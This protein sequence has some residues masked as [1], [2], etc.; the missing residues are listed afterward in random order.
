[1]VRKQLEAKQQKER[2]ELAKREALQVQEVKTWEQDKSNLPPIIHFPSKSALNLTPL[3]SP[4]ALSHQRFGP[5]S[6]AP[7]SNSLA[8]QRAKEKIEQLK[9]A[10]LQ[11]MQQFFPKTIAHTAA[12][13][14][15]RVAHTVTAVQK[16]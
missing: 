8:I 7:V 13:G 16:V 2:E 5:K 15:E 3:I 14:A 1:M 6:F 11:Q 12:K 9:A 10:K 4:S